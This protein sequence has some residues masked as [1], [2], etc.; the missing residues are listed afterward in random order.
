MEQIET[1]HF[2]FTQTTKHLA[3]D[4]DDLRSLPTRDEFE[5]VT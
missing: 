5:P 4:D 3:N 2:H 1:N